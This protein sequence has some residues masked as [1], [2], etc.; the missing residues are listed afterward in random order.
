MHITVLVFTTSQALRARSCIRRTADT[1]IGRLASA[2]AEWLSLT[3]ISHVES[4]HSEETDTHDRTKTLSL[5]LSLTYSNAT[6]QCDIRRSAP[7][8]ENAMCVL[9][10]LHRHPQ[11]A[12]ELILISITNAKRSTINLS[13][14]SVNSVRQLHPQF[15]LT[16]SSS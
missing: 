11:L 12:T 16:R 15:H 6:S 1:I 5:L 9:R 10:S 14:S 2:F 8:G 3:A 7:C 4:R 13:S